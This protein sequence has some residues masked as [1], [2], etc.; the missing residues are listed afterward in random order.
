MIHCNIVSFSIVILIQINCKTHCNSFSCDDVLLK[1]P[2]LYITVFSK[3]ISRPNPP[4][5]QL[6][7]FESLY[8]RNTGA[9][10]SAVGTK[11]KAL[12]PLYL[13]I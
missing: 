8:L 6:R 2:L 7:K 12:D 1:I 3:K 9:R 4:A 11:K 5:R 10:L 13:M